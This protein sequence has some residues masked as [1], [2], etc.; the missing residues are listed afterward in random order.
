MCLSLGPPVCM[1]VSVE[2]VLYV[3]PKYTCVVTLSVF[4]IRTC[5]AANDATTNTMRCL[6]CA[7]RYLLS[8][9]DARK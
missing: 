8:V 9:C 7:F 4:A 3:W 5:Q 2:I 6:L 1:F